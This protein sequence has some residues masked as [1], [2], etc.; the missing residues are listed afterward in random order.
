MFEGAAGLLDNARTHYTVDARDA[1]EEIFEGNYYFVPPYSP[2]LKPIERGFKLVKEYIKEHEDEAL[3]NPVEFIHQTFNL[4][5][6]G[7]EKAASV[8]NFWSTYVAVHNNFLN[9][10]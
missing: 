7:G 10:N 1:L 4:Y 3:L 8:F 5:S 9:E 2:H 6:I